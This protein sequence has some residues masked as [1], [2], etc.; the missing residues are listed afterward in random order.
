MRR[1]LYCF[2]ASDSSHF[3]CAE[4]ARGATSPE[5]SRWKSRSARAT[6]HTTRTIPQSACN[7]LVSEREGGALVGGG[8]GYLNTATAT[9]SS[10]STTSALCCCLSLTHRTASAHHRR[11][12]LP[13]LLLPP[14]P[15]LP[16]PLHRPSPLTTPP[17]LTLSP[18][19]LPL[20]LVPSPLRRFRGKMVCTVV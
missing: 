5:P 16:S 10:P 20:C 17:S 8:H 7:E 14:P 13:P 18:F 6:G 11:R 12:R 19:P 15:N 4:D 1:W 9:A 3:S 2:G